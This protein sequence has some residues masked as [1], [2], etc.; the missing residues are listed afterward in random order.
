MTI[1][2][3]V[4]ELKC[5]PGVWASFVRLRTVPRALNVPIS[6]AGSVS[7][8]STLTLYRLEDVS[9]PIA[10]RLRRHGRLNGPSIE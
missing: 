2:I 8:G 9:R 4:Q 1:E 6:K 5:L 3:T 10:A 7:G